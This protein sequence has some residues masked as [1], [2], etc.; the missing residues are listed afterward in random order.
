MVEFA[1]V[2]IVV[3]VVS[4]VDV[5][6]LFRLMVCILFIISFGV[7]GAVSVAVFVPLLPSFDGTDPSL[8]SVATVPVLLLL[9]L[10]L[11]KRAIAPWDKGNH[12]CNSLNISKTFGIL[13]VRI[14][15]IANKVAV[16]AE[17]GIEA[18]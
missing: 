17:G 7:K 5:P 18:V 4:F 2:T 3:V 1:V 6:E 16:S 8:V 13:F 14:A 11:Y 15:A 10:A 9:L 12:R